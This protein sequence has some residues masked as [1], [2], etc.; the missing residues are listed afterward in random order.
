[1]NKS[2]LR[3]AIADEIKSYSDCYKKSLSEIICSNIEKDTVFNDSETVGLYMPIRDEVDVKPLIDKYFGIKK[4]FLPYINCS[5]DMVY[6]PFD[7][8]NKMR[9]NRFGIKEPIVSDNFI[10]QNTLQL[11]IV[12][13]LAF[14]CYGYRL[15]RG[16]GYY[17]K[18]LKTNKVY[19]IGVSLYN[20]VEFEKDAWD[21]PL[22][23]IFNAS[24]K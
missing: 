4:I 6:I 24:A 19:T 14:D 15:G 10:N 18:F 21:M 23:R 22:N 17:D 8:W 12:P 1:M 13:A 20:Y 5:N 2:E 11:L 9:N 7:G 3:K 16:G